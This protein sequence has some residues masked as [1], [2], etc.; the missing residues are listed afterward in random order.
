[1]LE[2]IAAALLAA[3]AAHAAEP[4]VVI[5]HATIVDVR[6]GALLPGRTVT[7]RGGTIAQVVPDARG[8]SLRGSQ[9]IDAKGRFLMPGLWDMHMHFGGGP[10]LVQENLDLMPLYVANGVTAVRDCAGDEAAEVLKWRDEIAA[11]RL[12]G[13]TIFTSG[14]KLEGYKPVWKGTLEV[15]TPAEVD[16]ALDRLQAMRADFVKFTDNTLKPDIF[17]YA[18]GEA[19]RRGMKTSAHIPLAITVGQAVARRLKTVEHMAYAV[20]AG[21]AREA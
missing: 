21:S 2:L 18:V 8:R 11:G 6:A 3:G 10:E 1:M 15:G 14:P 17:L 20:K 13:P 16:A 9:T 4:D 7:V 12:V 5:R 19:H